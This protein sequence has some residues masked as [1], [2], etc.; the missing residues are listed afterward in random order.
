M[1]SICCSIWGKIWNFK[2]FGWVVATARCLKRSRQLMRETCSLPLTSWGR[3][4]LAVSS[5]PPSLWECSGTS[6]GLR[7]PWAILELCCSWGMLPPG[8][9]TCSHSTAAIPA[10]STAW[11][12]RMLLEQKGEGAMPGVAAGFGSHHR[13]CTALQ[14]RSRACLHLLLP[15]ELC[16]QG[17]ATDVQ[18]QGPRLCPG[19]DFGPSDH[20][21]LC[22]AESRA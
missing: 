7:E 22:F 21:P 16:F 17:N 8:P 19:V 12:L 2:A 18:V 20:I 4:G 5:L 11:L 13:A 3:T 6:C 9:G 14:P 10:A 1:G 15:G